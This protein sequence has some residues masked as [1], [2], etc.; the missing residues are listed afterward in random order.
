[1]AGQRKRE[2]ILQRRREALSD[3]G[4]LPTA[5]GGVTELDEALA[6]MEVALGGDSRAAEIEVAK[7]KENEAFGVE[8][9]AHYLQAGTGDGYEAYA[10]RAYGHLSRR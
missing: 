6:E 2:G 10:K 3:A 7:R 9:F 5:A 4:R 8:S 1:M